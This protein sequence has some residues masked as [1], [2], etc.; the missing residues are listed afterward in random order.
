MH[1]D[2]L[3]PLLHRHLQLELAVG[4]PEDLVGLGVQLLAQPLHLQLQHVER[5][6]TLL[7]LLDEL[8]ERT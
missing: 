8:L 3:L 7:L 2:L 6:H 5:D 4:E 1:L